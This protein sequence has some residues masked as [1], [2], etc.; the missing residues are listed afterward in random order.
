MQTQDNNLKKMTR[1]IEGLTPAPGGNKYQTIGN[2]QYL[3]QYKT[4]GVRSGQH[5]STDDFC[6]LII[7]A[8][9]N[10]YVRFCN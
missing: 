3:V 1:E 9:P 8:R 4:T 2:V 7:T 6:D 5:L 10:E